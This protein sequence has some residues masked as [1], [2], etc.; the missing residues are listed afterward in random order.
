MPFPHRNF[1]LNGAGMFLADQWYNSGTLW[2]AAGALAVLATGA[3]ATFVTV[4]L[5][6]PVRRL[7]CAMS[8]APLLKDSAQEM[9]G[10]LHITWDGTELKD[11]H[12]LELTLVSRGRRD[13]AKED[14]DLPL[15]FRVGSTIK[16][17]LRSSAG[18]SS[19]TFRAVSFEDDI[20][21]VGPALIRRRQSIRI[22]LLAV[23]PEPELSSAAAALRDVNVEV[24]TAESLQRHWAPR[25][26]VAAS[27]AVAAGAAGMVLIGLLIGHQPLR[28]N[29]A[30]TA[31]STSAGTLASANNSLL[32]AKVDLKSADQ[33]AQF[34]GINALQKI[35]KT[36]PSVQPAAIQ[37]LV[38]FILSESRAG[39]DDQ[40]VKTVVQAALNALRNR[41]PADDDG[42]TISLANT[43]L[44]NADI[45]GMDLS[46]ASLANADFDSADLNGANLSNANL[47][48]AFVGGAA[49]GGADLTGANL[50]GASFY[51]TLMCNGSAPIQPQRGYNCKVSG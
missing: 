50:T 4:W 26:K 32:T 43:N 1:D 8:A 44:T 17:I 21:R 46:G 3:V 2:G 30:P 41:D 47:N 33:A 27:V 45:S 7:D 18:P 25:T 40:P 5:A 20:L 36:S 14:F 16:A 51:K 39:N 31:H 6:N 48:Y 10:K 29:T 34:S 15:E 28:S 35:M 38:N 12:I 9:P 19:S 22:T 23:G 13:I 37:A 42:T 11:P 49:L 24:L